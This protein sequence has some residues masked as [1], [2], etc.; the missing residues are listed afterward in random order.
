MDCPR[1]AGQGTRATVAKPDD[2]T[3]LSVSGVIHH[4]ALVVSHLRHRAIGF[5]NTY[6]G[7]RIVCDHFSMFLVF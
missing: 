2:P 7:I 1:Q 6:D 4:L 3:M 5:L